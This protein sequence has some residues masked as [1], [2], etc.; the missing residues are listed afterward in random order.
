MTSRTDQSFSDV[1]LFMTSLNKC[2]NEGQGRLFPKCHVVD[3]HN[4][5]GF[6]LIMRRTSVKRVQLKGKTRNKRYMFDSIK[7]VQ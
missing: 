1:T 7:F 2:R 5:A 6:Y 3:K 4:I